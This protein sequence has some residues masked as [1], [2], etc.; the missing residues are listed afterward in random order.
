MLPPSL[1]RAVIVELGSVVPHY[2]GIRKIVQREPGAL[3][4]RMTAVQPK[5]QP[6]FFNFPGSVIY[7]PAGY[8]P[9]IGAIWVGRLMGFPVEAILLLGRLFNSALTIV[10]FYAA[11]RLT[12]IGALAVFWVGLMPMTA[13]ISASFGP[14]GMMIGGGAMLTTVGM[15]LL[16]DGKWKLQDLFAAALLTSPL[17]L[18]KLF[19][20]PLGLIGALPFWNARLAW[21]RLR[22][23]LAICIF[24]ALLAFL[25]TQAIQSLVVSVQPD[26]PP[27]GERLNAWLNEPLRPLALLYHTYFDRGGELADSLIT[28][29]W[30]NVGPVAGAGLSNWIALVIV[31]YAGATPASWFDWRSRIWLLLLAC[32]SL[33]LVSLAVYF[34]WTP[35][36]SNWIRGL[37]GRYFLPLVPAILFA[38]LPSRERIAT[39]SVAGVAVLMVEA[40]VLAL[41]AICR[42]FYL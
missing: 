38:A 7:S 28:F 23:P 32:G 12:P 35:A 10:L 13:S 6:R 24:L 21:W 16:R 40:N 5:E 29:G 3:F 33:G 36:G 11:L 17:T 18:A 8:L 42:A 25:W 26:V 15:R 20:L 30:L 27:V 4:T 1:G 37:Q 34:Y 19:Y 9:Q 2:P 39:I 22:A 14:D 41:T 31:I